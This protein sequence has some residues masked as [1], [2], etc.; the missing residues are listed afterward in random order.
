MNLAEALRAHTG[1]K[2]ALSV[3][4]SGV[5]VTLNHAG[6]LQR[7]LASGD[8]DS[9]ARGSSIFH[10]CANA[11]AGDGGGHALDE[12]VNPTDEEYAGFCRG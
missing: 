6:G 11:I 2:H 10:G 3:D 7:F 1:C 12:S 5:N 9:A 4:V 8:A